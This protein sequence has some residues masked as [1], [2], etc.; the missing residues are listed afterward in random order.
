MVT[1]NVHY[2]NGLTRLADPQP[3]EWLSDTM[4]VL[5]CTTRDDFKAFGPRYG[6][7]WSKHRCMFRCHLWLTLHTTDQDSGYPRGIHRCQR[8]RCGSQ[9]HMDIRLEPPLRGEF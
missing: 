7:F 8:K 2:P 6:N 4:Q 9:V 5:V 3:D 1:R